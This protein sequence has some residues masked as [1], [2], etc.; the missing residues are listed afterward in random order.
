MKK[1]LIA[2]LGTCLLLVGN[3]YSL[4][5]PL[6]Y[7][8]DRLDE[9]FEKSKT[10]N[11][12]YIDH[13]PMDEMYFPD[14]VYAVGKIM[15]WP[16]DEASLSEL[17][18]IGVEVKYYSEP[19]EESQPRFVTS[20]DY[21]L[22]NEDMYE[23]GHGLTTWPTYDKGWRY[24]I[25]IGS[26]SDEYLYVKLEDLKKVTQNL[27]QNRIESLRKSGCSDL[28]LSWTAS[29][30]ADGYESELLYID[31]GLFEKGMYASPDFARP[32]Y[33]DGF[34]VALSAACVI[35]LIGMMR[36]RLGDKNV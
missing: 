30:L 14:I 26:R 27:L 21:I 23:L 25:P 29:C 15:Y 32:I 6:R 16:S 34:T 17:D 1:F 8:S 36:E 33:F 5:N 13:T 24:A 22:R 7:Y 11:Q 2:A 12:Q 4:H 35:F 10:N 9:Y 31:A 28:E 19:G 3:I 18:R 20:P